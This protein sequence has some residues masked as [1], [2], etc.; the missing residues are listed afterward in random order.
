MKFRNHGGPCTQLK[1]GLGGAPWVWLAAFL[2]LLALW[3][4]SAFNVPAYENDNNQRTM[5]DGPH[6]VINGLAL[7]RLMTSKTSPA[8]FKRYE[9][10]KLPILRGEG[11]VS[12]G[13]VHFDTSYRAGPREGSFIWWI[14]E[15]GYT[16]DEPELYAS[17]RHFYDP[18]A[19]S[20][21]TYLTDH[22]ESIDLMYQILST[23]ASRKVLGQTFYPQVDAREWAISG[24]ANEG[25]G[26]NEYAWDRGLEAM[27]DAFAA[28]DPVEKSHLFVKA[29]R[30]LGETMHLVAD[31]TSPA[32]VRN[33]SHPGLPLSAF[34]F[35]ETDPNLGYLK[36]DAYE[37]YTSHRLVMQ[38]GGGTVDSELQRQIV[39]TRNPEELFD[40]I[41]DYTQENFFSVDT[42]SG[43][44]HLG[45][46]VTSANGQRDFPS[47]KL[48]AAD[49]RIDSGN[50]VKT[51]NG[52]PVCIAHESW[53]SSTGWGSPQHATQ[54]TYPC[55]QDQVS[56]LVPVAIQGA[57]K[58]ADWFIPKMEVN[59]ESFDPDKGIL[60][61]R[62]IHRN[63]DGAYATPLQFNA[64][65]PPAF[66]LYMNGGLQNWDKIKLQIVNG[67][68]TADLSKLDVPEKSRFS[69]VLDVGGM[70]VRSDELGAA[71]SVVATGPGWGYKLVSAEVPPKN[72]PPVEYIERSRKEGDPFTESYSGKDNSGSWTGRQESGK[73]KELFGVQTVQWRVPKAILPGQ[74]AEFWIEAKISGIVGQVK[75]TM[76]VAMSGDDEGPL[77]NLAWWPV[78]AARAESD[79]A[80]AY[81]S[82]TNYP[83]DRY[84]VTFPDRNDLIA[85]LQK[86]KAAKW[87]MT[88]R[89]HDKMI[90]FNGSV[91]AR[92]A[93][94]PPPSKMPLVSYTVFEARSP[95]SAESAVPTHIRVN[96]FLFGTEFLVASY[97]YQWS[98][99]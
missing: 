19:M 39:A 47:P 57:M 90:V 75:P 88:L 17:F 55:V 76:F 66:Y 63:A 51:V 94:H 11:V 9:F 30:S 54:M 87:A 48:R 69:L 23:R 77:N 56:I 67:E 45:R 92:A 35:G 70:R 20:G 95:K 13:W 5:K 22:L 52:R 14:M 73:N 3:L 99:D 79:F 50:Y 96:V 84:A 16:A 38:Y 28:V 97:V 42:I 82:D 68:I 78:V 40:V 12:P 74:P 72:R 98:N 6:R 60:K 33:D 44:D 10:E 64:S 15:G 43:V 59:L 7:K 24:P 49:F 85:E 93:G 36:A 61:G 31:M 8:A 91:G 2:L 86:G 29:W 25:L 37:S 46:G 58:L 34:G 89:D 62:L 27:R 83:E 32:H 65:Q 18:K 4:G 53:L 80:K 81:E 41:A 71:P 1:T 26:R 21:K